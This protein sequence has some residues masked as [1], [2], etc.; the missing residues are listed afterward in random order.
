MIEVQTHASHSIAF[1]MFLQF[2]L[3]D[4]VTLT[5]DLILIGG[6]GLV[7]DYPC[8]KFGIVVSAVWFDC[9]YKQTD[10]IT[11]RCR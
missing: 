9:E 4:N 2:A 3:W 8:E 5:F 10:R 11:H 1:N 6:L 7:M